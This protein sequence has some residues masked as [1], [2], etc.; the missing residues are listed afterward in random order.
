MMGLPTGRNGFCIA[1]MV[2]LMARVPSVLKRTIG[3][4]TPV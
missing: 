3:I 4:Q 1:N 2:H